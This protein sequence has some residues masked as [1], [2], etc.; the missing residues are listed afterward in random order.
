MLGASATFG[1]GQ[2]DDHTIASELVRLGEHD[3]VALDILNLGVPGW[4]IWQEANAF[5]ARLRRAEAPPELVIVLDGFNDALGT[6]LQSVTDGS[7][8]VGP[9]LLD[10][11]DVLEMTSRRLDAA[12]VGGGAALGRESAGRYLIEQRRLDKA[13][14]T[15]RSTTRYFFQPDAFAT[16]VQRKAIEGIYRFDPTMFDRAEADEA[17]EAASSTLEPTV[18]N[19]RHLFDLEPR[20]VFGDVVHTNERGARLVAAEIYAVLSDEITALAAAR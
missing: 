2:R 16:P 15:A 12:S 3:G 8:G 4:T 14:A 18:H 13:A 20:P 5:E 17:L 11:D 19:I 10:N 6:V 7:I 9:T 1:I